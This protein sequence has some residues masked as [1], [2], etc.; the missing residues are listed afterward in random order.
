M[1][2]LTLLAAV[3]PVL[4]AANDVPQAINSQVRLAYHGNNAMMVSWNT[5]HKV[6]TPT[7]QWGLS[8]DNLTYNATSM[9][10]VTYPTSTTYNNHVLITGLKPGTTYWYM[11]TPVAPGSGGTPFN[12]TTA[13]RAGDMTP[14][15]MAVA[16]DLGT[17][18]RRGLSSIGY[19]GE[20]S[21]NILQPGDMNS[22]QSMERRLD[23]IDFLAHPGDIAY[24][25]YWLTQELHN[26]LPNTTIADGAEQYELT[27]ND[28]YDQ[29]MPITSVKPYMVGPG[30]HEANCDNGGTT[31]KVHN[32]TYGNSICLPGQTNF[33]GYKHHF[34]MPGALTGGTGNFWYSYEHGMTHYIQLNTETNI[35]Y[36]YVGGSMK[37]GVSPVNKTENAQALWLEADLKSVDRTKTPWVVVFMHRPFAGSVDNGTSG[38]FCNGCRQVWEPLFNK[39]NVDLVMAGH[40]HLYERIVPNYNFKIDSNGLNN[41]S[42]P[43]YITNGAAGHYDGM[44]PFTYP[45]KPYHQF[46]LDTTNASYGWSRLTFH[47]CTHLTHDY[48]SAKNNTIIDTATLYKARSCRSLNGTSSTPTPTP[49]S[50]HVSGATKAGLSFVLLALPAA[51]F[52]I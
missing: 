24:A 19:K 30:N 28:F 52:L 1:K 48:V 8:K 33:T 26:Y 42:N 10:S 18:G 47:N 37:L 25:D 11:P 38:N 39:Y 35:G 20:T 23:E 4:V 15:K 50:F 43:W 27:L 17:M 49:T 2:F 41:P 36:G 31:D 51:L 16:I 40:V 44:D 12:F 34:R 29:M 22:I 32:I 21:T 46:G 7:V 5:Y 45:L 14:Y 13:R 3:A 6:D 9:D